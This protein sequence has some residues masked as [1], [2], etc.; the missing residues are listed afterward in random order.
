MIPDRLSPVKPFWYQFLPR[1][2]LAGVHTLSSE[3]LSILTFMS[4]WH[5]FA[6]NNNELL[7]GEQIER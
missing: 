4:E 5:I 2:T 3:L 7:E 6:N 1:M